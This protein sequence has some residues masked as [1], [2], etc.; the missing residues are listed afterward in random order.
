MD[1]IF[2]YNA[3]LK[4]TKTH[5]YYYGVVFQNDELK[6]VVQEEAFTNVKDAPSVKKRILS[7]LENYLIIPSAVSQ[8]SE[9]SDRFNDQLSESSNE[10][11]PNSFESH[12]NTFLIDNNK[13][14]DVNL[15][16]GKH[17]H[18]AYQPYIVQ[19]RGKEFVKITTIVEKTG[20]DVVNIQIND[21]FFYL[22]DHFENRIRIAVAN[23]IQDALSGKITVYTDTKSREK[24]RVNKMITDAI[25]NSGIKNIVA[26]VLDAENL[27]TSTFL[28]RYSNIQI[29]VA[30]YSKDTAEKQKRTFDPNLHL[31]EGTYFDVMKNLCK[32]KIKAN[33]YFADYTKTYFSQKEDVDYIIEKGCTQDEIIMALTFS[34]RV[35]KGRGQG[36]N[37]ENLKSIMTDIQATIGKNNWSILNAKGLVYRKIPDT[38]SAANDKLTKYAPMF[39][40]IYHLSKTKRD[41]KYYT[42]SSENRS[43]I[44]RDKDDDFWEVSPHIQPDELL[45]NP[46]YVNVSSIKE[47]IDLTQDSESD[48][49]SY[50]DIDTD[51]DTYT[52]H[53]YKDSNF[54][55][56][57]NGTSGTSDTSD[58]DDTVD[59]TDTIIYKPKKRKI[60]E[61]D[62][63]LD[64]IPKYKEKDGVWYKFINGNYNLITRVPKKLTKLYKKQ[65]G[66][67]FKYN[68][69][70]GTSDQLY[71][72]QNPSE[73]DKDTFIES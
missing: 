41:N 48:S 42:L 7:Q 3:N 19:K 6:T 51:T 8:E 55:N 28:V 17:G 58:T 71:R 73:D 14:G 45:L 33:V 27:Q 38:F 50:I 18:P 54:S 21:T 13:F 1:D 52:D 39:F 43:S 63:S 31:R 2:A 64:L 46:G 29:Y 61:S 35:G 66:K 53:T 49:E 60:E 4:A 40:V 23:W 15:T 72:T 65:F 56:F 16:I 11:L 30:E 44:Y 5:L 69:E 67:W 47:T 34:Y 26:V 70:T 12:Q 59:T 68:P 10:K 32:K 57:S 36:G 37:D 22:K 25:D 20:K 62:E 9:R 24:Q